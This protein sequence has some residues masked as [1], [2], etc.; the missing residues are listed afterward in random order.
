M[1]KLV[2]LNPKFIGYARSASGEGVNFDCPT[3]GPKHVL[4]AYFSNPIDGQP[5]KISEAYWMRHGETFEELTVSPSIL[6]PCFHG[7]IEAGRVF[8][9][10]ESAA[11]YPKA[12]KD[13]QIELVA[14]S[15][16]QSIAYAEDIVAKVKA[17]WS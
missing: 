8:D 1:K 4:A 2:D 14:L 13:G 12:N 15:P 7:W 9:I 11:T 6:Y 5:A 17:I 10:S 16:L 3:C